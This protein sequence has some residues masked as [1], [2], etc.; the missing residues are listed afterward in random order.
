MTLPDGVTP[1]RIEVP[2]A[3]LAD[4]RERL[5]R[6]RWPEAETVGDWSQGAPLAYVRELARYWAEEYDWRKAEARMSAYP[7]FRTEIDGLG[8]HFLHARSPHADALP[9]VLTHGW[10]GSVVEFLEAIGP[11]T[12][13][14][15]HGGDAA[16]AFHVVCPS[17]P[18]YGFSDKPAEP[19]W[20]VERIGLAW[21]ELMGRLG[22]DRFGAQGGDWGS[23]VTVATARAAGERIAGIHLNMP[24]VAPDADTFTDLTPTEQKTLKDLAYHREWGTGYSK[25]QSTRPQTLGYGLSDSPT[26]QLA[27]I[28]EKFREWTDCDGHP[29]N[30]LTRDQM[31]D[32]IT[33]YWLTGTATSSARLY[34]ESF[35]SP[36]LGPVNAPTGC[37]IFPYEIIRASRRWAEKRFTD[38]RYWNELDKGGHFAAFEQP[39]L[40]VEE[41]RRF[42]RLVR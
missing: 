12:D 18:G 7:H 6:T 22:Y 23:M 9:L 14:T 27:W 32:N 39:G 21:A 5:N 2:D 20:N 19:G 15:A 16:D 26:G 35:H 29:E 3:D 40:F 11:L 4:L 38:L 31:L 1:F 37:S 24:V 28:V 17:L 10:P 36:D 25:I 41:V 42:F 30:V 8:I 34:W 13:P 33:L